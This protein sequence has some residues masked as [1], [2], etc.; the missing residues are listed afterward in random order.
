MATAT[1]TVPLLV[2][3]TTESPVLTGLAFALE[4]VPRLASFGRAGALVARHGASHV[5]RMAAAVRALVLLAAVPVLAGA[6]SGAATTVTVMALAALNGVLSQ[7]SYVA[8]ETAGAVASQ[9]TTRP[10]RVQGVLLGIDQGAMLAG[11]AAGSALLQWAG[12]GWL[13]G[14]VAAM[15]ATA[16]AAVP[17]GPQ[18]PKESSIERGSV[19]A[20]SGWATLRS[21]PALAW[22][23]AGLAVSN[24]A[25]GT[26]EAA[27]PVI[28]VRNL[29]QSSASVGAVWSV[30]AA[31][32]LLVVAASR[33]AIERWGLWPVG[34]LSAGVA[35]AAC[36]GVAQA[37]RFPA[38][39]VLV[40]VLMASEAG[41]TVVLRTLRSQLVP[42]E[43][44]APTLAATILILLLPFPLA[45]VLVACTPPAVL[46]QLLTG[47]AALQAMALAAAFTKARTALA[48]HRTAAAS[49]G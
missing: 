29:G 38:Y 18:P 14:A 1:Y 25:T 17:T 16:A 32:T 10:H 48:P 33:P 49:S 27:A 40:A 19:P 36:L 5:M 30:A 39:T 41:M 21:R 23:V 12:P 43:A 4:W 11:P 47:L 28:V 7:F 45:G 37:H 8:A 34:A 24:L 13:L 2:L 6:A 26:L 9:A 46:S 22:L 15:S 31:A 20:M 42:Q 35:S 3:A 44:F